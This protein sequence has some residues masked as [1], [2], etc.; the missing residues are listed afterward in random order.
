MFSAILCRHAGTEANSYTIKIEG[1]IAGLTHSVTAFTGGATDPVLTGI[2][3]DNQAIAR[4][5]LLARNLPANSDVYVTDECNAD[6]NFFKARAQVVPVK[7]GPVSFGLAAQYVDGSNFT[8]NAEIGAVVRVA[9]KLP[10]GMFGKSDIQYF[11]EANKLEGYAFIS[12]KNALADA[13]WKHGFDEGAGFVRL[14]FDR[15]LGKK[16]SIGV[17]G[18]F[19]GKC[20]DLQTKY[21]G[22]RLKVNF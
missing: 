4:G 14:G 12:S 6:S 7:C 13:L 19:A 11:P 16:V 17:E 3:A 21:V 8:G 2:V 9:G 5:E 10:K 18:K 20:S 15:K 22:G 1:S